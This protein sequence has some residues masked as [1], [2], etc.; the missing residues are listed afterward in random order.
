MSNP[1]TTATDEVG[2]QT[3]GCLNN[4]NI[5]ETADWLPPISQEATEPKPAAA[6][7]SIATAP[8]TAAAIERDD[9]IVS[10]CGQRAICPP[11]AKTARCVAFYKTGLQEGYMGGPSRRKA[12]AMFELA[13]KIQSGPLAGEHYRLS[14]I[15]TAELYEKSGLVTM[16]RS[17]FGRDIVQKN[18]QQNRLKI[19]EIVG[20]YATIIVK[21]DIKNGQAFPKITDVLPPPANAPTINSTFDPTKNM[22]DFVRKMIAHQLPRSQA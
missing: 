15:V 12:V 14:K 2:S 20:K 16:L 17:W 19:S 8:V 5:Q 18:G 21:H 9:E 6:T 11:G 3:V 7:Q 4:S 10:E 1:N 13:D 22:P